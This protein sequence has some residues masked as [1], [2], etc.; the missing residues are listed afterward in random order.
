[1]LQEESGVDVA[2]SAKN[3]RAAR[4][5]VILRARDSAVIS[6]FAA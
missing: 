2:Q 6:R 5:V 4:V 3:K 1:M